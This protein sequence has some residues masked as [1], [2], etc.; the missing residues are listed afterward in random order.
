MAKFAT[1]DCLHMVWGKDKVLQGRLEDGGRIVKAVEGDSFVKASEDNCIENRALLEAYM[2]R[3]RGCRS[4]DI[5]DLESFKAQL[6]SLHTTFA[7]NRAKVCGSKRPRALMEATLELVQANAHLDGKALKR[8][9]SYA[10]RRFLSPHEP[11]DPWMHSS[12]YVRTENP[13][14]ADLLE[15]W[16]EKEL[17]E[18]SGKKSRWEQV[19]DADERA[20]DQDAFDEYARECSED[21]E[22]EDAEF[23]PLL[24]MPPLPAPVLAEPV[25]DMPIP[26]PVLE[27]VLDM[28]PTASVLVKGK[29]LVHANSS[30]SV[31]SDATT[32]ILGQTPKTPQPRGIVATQVPSTQLTPSP[33]SLPS[34]VLYKEVLYVADSPR[35]MVKA[36]PKEKNDDAED[37]S[38]KQALLS[39]LANL[40]A[41]QQALL[42]AGAKLASEPAPTEL[43]TT[44]A[45]ATVDNT[46]A[47]DKE[48]DRLARL[49]SVGALVE[50][51]V[52]REQQ[53]DARKNRKAKQEA[54][55]AAA[56][57]RKA[58]Q[59]NDGELVVGAGGDGAGE[60]VSKKRRTAAKSKAKAKSRK[61]GPPEVPAEAG[62]LVEA[63]AEAED[64]IE[65]PAEAEDRAEVALPKP[66][67][68]RGK[69]GQGRGRG[70]K[71]AEKPKSG[72]GKGKGTKDQKKGKGKN[73]KKDSEEAPAPERRVSSKRAPKSKA[74]KPKSALDLE[75]AI[76][77]IVVSTNGTLQHYV[78][79][80]YW[81]RPGVGIKQLSDG[82]QVQYLGGKGI[83]IS[84]LLNAAIDCARLMDA[85]PT[86][87]K[88]HN[89]YCY[90]RKQELKKCVS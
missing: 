66:K 54:A 17:Y 76:R 38:K 80:V 46:T 14:F 26:P 29:P 55:K 85:D 90:K 19:E 64:P 40:Q 71:A 62:A 72:K 47:L 1:V 31:C 83:G 79:M 70:K 6:L 43:E 41:A 87:I 33:P 51:A 28:P 49:N 68:G 8:L 20:G 4:L 2:V 84:I 23:D 58:G 22:E 63:P 30:S 13:D 50:S 5:P 67:K 82:K 10:R 21:A 18:K 36:E 45:E 59:A 25:L 56:K 65:A 44:E 77:K 37:G 69:G 11:K 9:L 16:G 48:A 88:G 75:E 27:P 57:A 53:L 86:D 24:E 32:L 15:L 52:T 35:K 34:Q 39:E 3:Q 74:A 60:P 12:I 42:S 81:T 73:K 7:M 89:Q 78:V 61:Q